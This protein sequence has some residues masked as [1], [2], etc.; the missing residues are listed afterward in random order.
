MKKLLLFVTAVMLLCASCT[1]SC[2]YGLEDSIQ[3]EA[4]KEWYG[5]QRVNVFNVEVT[6]KENMNDG[7][8]VYRF[9]YD[10]AVTNIYGKKIFYEYYGK[11]TKTGTEYVIDYTRI[12]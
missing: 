9:N 10:V 6:D 11:A 7:S 1:E 8:V 2:P 4:Y 5:A 12:R 3:R